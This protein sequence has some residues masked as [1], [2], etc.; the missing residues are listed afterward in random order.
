M[1][2]LNWTRD[3]ALT[4]FGEYRVTTV[5]DR[6]HLTL[7]RKGR[8]ERIGGDYA[9]PAKAKAAAVVDCVC[10]RIS[11]QEGGAV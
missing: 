6:Y 10:R 3:S 4:R 8:S 11:D 5:L 9:T 1:T 2:Q 7:H